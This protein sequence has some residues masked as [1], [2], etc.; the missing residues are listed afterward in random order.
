MNVQY[1]LIQELSFYNFKLVYN[2]TEAMKNYF[3]I[4]RWRRSTQT[5]KFCLGCKNLDNQA[6]SDSPKTINSKVMLQVIEAYLV[7]IT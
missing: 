5:K 6:R 7:S 3:C 2:T 1:S 4:K